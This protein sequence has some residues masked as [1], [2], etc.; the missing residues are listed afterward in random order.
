MNHKVTLVFITSRF[1]FP[2]EKGDKLRAYYLIKG[3]SE[4]FNIHLMALTD[5]T[6]QTAW[7]DELTPYTHKI[8]VFKLSRWRIGLRLLFNILYSRPFQTAYFTDFFIQREILKKL[9]QIQPYHIFCQMIRPAEYV[10]HYHHCHKTLDY[11]DLLSLGMERRKNR[12]RGLK[13]RMVE[14]ESHRLN[15]YEQRIFHYF[16]HQLMISQQ[17]ANGLPYPHRKHIQVIPNGIDTHKFNPSTS[18]EA[19]F[20]AVFVGNLSYAPNVD[21]VHWL[22]DNLLA[23]RPQWNVLIAGANPSSKL[24]AYLKGKGNVRMLGWQDSIQSVYSRGKI[25]LAPMQIGTG[26]QNKLL[27]AMAMELPCITTSLA[28]EAIPNSPVIVANTSE[29]MLQAMDHLLMNPEYAK[30]LGREG[31]AFVQKHYAWDAWTEKIRRIIHRH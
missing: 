27:E 8:E 13:K 9:H 16:E 5:E 3:L 18:I 11:M 28:A 10:K 1:P 6:V 20:D 21:A 15:E 17:D 4:Y 25:F 19:T 24:D 22:C 31:R 30:Q 26:M 2:L 7:I 12:L 23:Q 14:M 29:E